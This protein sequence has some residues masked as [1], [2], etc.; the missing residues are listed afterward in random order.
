[1]AKIKPYTG[2]KTCVDG[3]LYRFKNGFAVVPGFRMGERNNPFNPWH[4]DVVI[5]IK[6][7]N[8]LNRVDNHGDE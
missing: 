5:S 7:F 3:E 4:R 2:I 1:M 6:E 8:E